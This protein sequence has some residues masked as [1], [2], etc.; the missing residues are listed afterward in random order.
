MGV[1]QLPED[2]S[3]PRCDSIGTQRIER[4]TYDVNLAETKV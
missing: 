1:V 3:L 4:Y 2:L